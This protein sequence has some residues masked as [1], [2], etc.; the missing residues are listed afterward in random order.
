MTTLELGPVV[1]VALPAALADLFARAHIPESY[2]HAYADALMA[3]GFESPQALALL[4]ADDLAHCGIT[5]K[6]H[7]KLLLQAVR[8]PVEKPGLILRC[9][10]CAKPV[11]FSQGA[12]VASCECGQR[13]YMPS[14]PFKVACRCGQATTMPMGVS[15]ADC[16]AC[17]ERLGV[18]ASKQAQPPESQG[19]Q[20]DGRT[21]VIPA[22]KG[23]VEKLLGC[24]LP[25]A[26]HAASQGRVLY[27][28]RK[29]GAK[30][31]SVNAGDLVTV[32]H[33]H[34]DGWT[35]VLLAS[36]ERGLCPSSHV[37]VV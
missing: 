31:V 3:E 4:D 26:T 21:T 7:V 34:D 9:P 33:E 18:F 15:E 14:Q 32:L 10:K 35:E 20:R 12:S 6:A 28:Y 8:S 30:E 22:D 17:G 5:A 23:C 24:L 37:I 11:T 2:H 1:V 27:D 25:A 29:A 19:M 36:G 13:L 16:A